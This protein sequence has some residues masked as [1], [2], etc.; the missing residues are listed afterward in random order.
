MAGEDKSKISKLRQQS[1]R[2]RREYEDLSSKQD[3]A[4]SEYLRTRDDSHLRAVTREIEQHTKKLNRL[5]GSGAR[6]HHSGHSSQSTR[7]SVLLGIQ[8]DALTALATGRL[9]RE[10][11]ASFVDNEISKLT[12]AEA[13]DIYV[14]SATLEDEEANVALVEGMFKAAQRRR[15]GRRP[16]DVAGAALRLAKLLLMSHV[17]SWACSIVDGTVPKPTTRTKGTFK[18]GSLAPTVPKRRG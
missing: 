18:E 7:D 1:R 8:E 10:D 4:L 6:T 17:T 14:G 9:A 5:K 11:L 13:L 2:V 3:W 15:S 16:V 12:I